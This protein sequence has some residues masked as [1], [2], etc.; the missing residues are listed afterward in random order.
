[1]ADCIYRR[2]YQYYVCKCNRYSLLNMFVHDYKY[3]HKKF[4]TIPF[5]LST[6]HKN[7]NYYFHYYYYY[8]FCFERKHICTLCV[9]KSVGR[10]VYAFHLHWNKNTLFVSLFFPLQ[11][12]EVINYNGKSDMKPKVYRT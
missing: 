3:H 7:I 8:W 6:F 5:H 11:S 12:D 10:I 4:L 9:L 2:N 1:M